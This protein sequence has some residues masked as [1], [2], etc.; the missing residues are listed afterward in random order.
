M[1]T[2]NTNK[3]KAH[4]LTTLIINATD[5]LKCLSR[6]LQATTGHFSSWGTNMRDKALGRVESVSGYDYTK[7]G[8]VTA[9]SFWTTHLGNVNGDIQY[10]N[11]KDFPQIPE[12]KG[13]R[14]KTY[15]L[16]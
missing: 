12:V 9:V 5:P 15:I 7:D 16:D 14:R 1:S 4:P 13:A 8:T 10:E 11:E 2:S 6:A 3:D